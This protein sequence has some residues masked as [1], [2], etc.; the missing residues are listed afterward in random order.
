MSDELRI[1]YQSEVR[2][3]ENFGGTYTTVDFDVTPIV[4]AWQTGGLDNNGLAIASY[5]IWSRMGFY[6]SEYPMIPARPMLI[7]NY[8]PLACGH[9][10]R[11]LQRRGYHRP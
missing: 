4:Q 6:S 1:K 7:V 10:G 5:I 2:I 8:I 9:P 3:D 11:A